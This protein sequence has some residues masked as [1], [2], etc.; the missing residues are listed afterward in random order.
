MLG[1]PEHTPCCAVPARAPGGAPGGALPRTLAQKVLWNSYPPS[2]FILLLSEVLLLLCNLQVTMQGWNR[3]SDN[4]KE[5]IARTGSNPFGEWLSSITDKTTR[6]RIRTRISRLRL[7]N[8]GD[9]RGGGEGVNEPRLDFGPGYRVYYGLVGEALVLLLSGGDKSSQDRDI[10][11][12]KR[13]WQ[14][15]KADNAH[16]RL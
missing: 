7:G 11:E 2:F 1:R 10:R 4:S 9:C 8:F 15:F 3:E 5:Y 6:A 14:E 16:E 12:A 13:Y